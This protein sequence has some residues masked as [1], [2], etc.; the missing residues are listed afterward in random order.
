MSDRKVKVIV[1]C[2][3]EYPLKESIDVLCQAKGVTVHSDFESLVEDIQQST[4][5][6]VTESEGSSECSLEET[7]NGPVVV[8]EEAPRE[9]GFE[10]VIS[11]STEMA[12]LGDES[13]IVV[14]EYESLEDYSCKMAN[15]KF[16]DNTFYA[17]VCKEN[18]V[19]HVNLY[20]TVNGKILSETFR[21]EKVGEKYPEEKIVFANTYKFGP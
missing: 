2:P 4:S 8:T 20:M 19:A 21:L 13:L 1:F 6:Q 10:V 12:T 9:E 16:K 17:G 3:D 15:I 5:T 18:D 14:S 11:E 7:E